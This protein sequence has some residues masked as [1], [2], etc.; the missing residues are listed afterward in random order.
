MAV[1]MQAVNKFGT[2]SVQAL[3]LQVQDEAYT[4]AYYLLG[5]ETAAEAATQAAFAGVARKS[6]RHAEQFRQDVLRGVLKGIRAVA[7]LVPSTGPAS[8]G[9]REEITLALMRLPAVERS[10]LVLVD[11]LG[12][13]YDTAASVMGC[14]SKQITHLLAQGRMKFVPGS[15]VQEISAVS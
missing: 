2:V 6:V 10:A 3:A 9:P 15:R 14:S 13:N 1:M 4:Y 12:L 5:D 11:V 7:P 8:A